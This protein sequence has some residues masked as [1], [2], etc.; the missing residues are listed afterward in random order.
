MLQD[1]YD[2]DCIFIST[3]EAVRHALSVMDPPDISMISKD[4]N[5]IQ[6]GEDNYEVTNEVKD[7]LQIRI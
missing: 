3:E 2:F 7:N 6:N 5:F 1:N 4:V